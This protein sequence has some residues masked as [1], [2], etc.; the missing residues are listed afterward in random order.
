MSDKQKIVVSGILCNA[1]GEVLLAK[2]PVTKK[3]A[4]G[5]Y[6]L[7]GG[8]VEYSETLEEALVREM[9]EEFRLE[10]LPGSIVNTFS[11]TTEDSHTIGVTFTV[12]TSELP[13]N[14]WFD[15]ADTEEIVW[16]NAENLS[17]YLS[18]TDHDSV[19]LQKFFAA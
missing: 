6:H 12:V 8:H 11:Y 7:P 5:V 2:R 18:K 4:P 16:V 10:T 13:E 9:Q 19:T 14:I 17:Q 3:I 1:K 15:T